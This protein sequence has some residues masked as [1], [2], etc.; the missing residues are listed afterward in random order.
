MSNEKILLVGAGPM[1]VDYA[2]VL[3]SLGKEIIVVGRGKKSAQ[4]FSEQTKTI[5]ILGGLDKYLSSNPKLPD[6]AIVAVSEEQ[7]GIATRQLLEAGIKSIL[8]EK[9]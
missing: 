1:A 4:N 5:P 9:P 2:K 8:V 3:I 7:L 6:T